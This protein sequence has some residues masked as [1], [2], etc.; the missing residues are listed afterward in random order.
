LSAALGLVPDDHDAQ[1]TLADAYIA[2]ERIGEAGQLLEQAIGKHTRRRSPELAQLQHR[3]ARL[4]Q[5]VED[6]SLQ[7]Q[8]LSAAM[9][10]DKNNPDV[11]GE[12]ALLAME[13]EEWDKALLALRAVTLC[14]VEGSMSRA[15]AFLH[16]ARIAHTR[17]EARRALLWARKAHSEDPALEAAVAFLAELGEG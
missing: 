16:Q 5:A 9:D 10:A 17:G 14:R 2:T 1:V 11:A 6:R 13:L 15:V 8:W 3:M 4:A 7:F 12:L